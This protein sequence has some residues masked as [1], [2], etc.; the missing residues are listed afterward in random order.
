MSY[1]NTQIIGYSLLSFSYLPAIVSPR[2]RFRG[3]CVTVGG[4]V[5][6]AARECVPIRDRDETE[7]CSYMS[8]RDLSLWRGFSSGDRKFCRGVKEC[9]R[10]LSYWGILCE[11]HVWRKGIISGKSHLIWWSQST[12]YLK[13]VRDSSIYIYSRNVTCTVTYS[14]NT[15]FTWFYTCTCTAIPLPDP[16]FARKQSISYY[17]SRMHW[18][19]E[20]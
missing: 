17:H 10:C 13:V 20:S 12:Y 2:Y 6:I 5:S 15:T 19:S 7:W 14:S 16:S 1:T 11:I 18:L 4:G 3:W 9:L 8:L